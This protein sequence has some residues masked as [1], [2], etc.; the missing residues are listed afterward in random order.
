MRVHEF[1]KGQ[2]YSIIRIKLFWSN[3]ERSGNQWG[4]GLICVEHGEKVSTPA[5]FK[6]AS[7]AVCSLTPSCILHYFLQVIAICI[8]LLWLVSLFKNTKHSL[9]QYVFW[10]YLYLHLVFLTYPFLFSHYAE[11]LQLLY[12]MHLSM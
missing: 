3:F 1:L 4:L 12:W 5:V 11:C 6:T 2:F 8:F 10:S 7:F 9:L